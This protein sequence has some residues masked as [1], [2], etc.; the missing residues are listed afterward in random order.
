MQALAWNPYLP[1]AL[2]AACVPRHVANLAGYRADRLDLEF[3]CADL[4]SL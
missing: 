2:F 4:C 1:L 3:V